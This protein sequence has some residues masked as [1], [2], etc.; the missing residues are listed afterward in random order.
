MELMGN[1]SQD[2]GGTRLVPGKWQTFKKDF[3]DAM[4]MCG[5]L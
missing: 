5:Y 1:R 4:W 2:E 3:G